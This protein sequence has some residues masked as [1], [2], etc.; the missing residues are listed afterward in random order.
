[1]GIYNDTDGVKEHRLRGL[2]EC[3]GCRSLRKQTARNRKRRQGRARGQPTRLSH[4]IDE[5]NA[6]EGEARTHEK[7]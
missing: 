4:G 1:M 2:H 6:C 5:E 7:G 3:R